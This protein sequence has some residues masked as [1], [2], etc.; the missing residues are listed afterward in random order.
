MPNSIDF[1][2]GIFLH[3]IPVRI[4]VPW[5]NLNKF[6]KNESI[7]PNFVLTRRITLISNQTH[8]NRGDWG[9]PTS[10][11]FA[12]FGLSP[13]DNDSD[14]KKVAKKYKPFQIP[15][16]LLVILLLFTSFNA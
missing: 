12:K 7:K 2:R 13:I 11:I 9:A 4:I 5:T 16:K 8:R 14:K 3:V 10:H 1:Y 15:Q 6:E